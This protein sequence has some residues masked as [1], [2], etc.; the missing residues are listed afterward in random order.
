MIRDYNTRTVSIQISLYPSN[1]GFRK[2]YREQT[3][4]NKGKMT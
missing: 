3:G 2:I 1:Q 4:P